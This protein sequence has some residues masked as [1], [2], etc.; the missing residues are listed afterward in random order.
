MGRNVVDE[1]KCI[2]YGD[3]I[4]IINQLLSLSS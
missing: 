1:M 4:A 3:A 2:D